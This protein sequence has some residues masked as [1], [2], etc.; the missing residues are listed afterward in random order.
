MPVT[1]L[2]ET[3]LQALGAHSVGEPAPQLPPLHVSLFVHALPSEHAA[4]SLPATLPQPLTASQVSTVHGFASVQSLF[5]G[6]PAHL[7][8]AHLSLWVQ[9]TS[10]LQLA[11]LNVGTQ[12]VADRVNMGVK[13]WRDAGL[14]VDVKPLAY[15]PEVDAVSPETLMRER[16][17]MQRQRQ[18][19]GRRLLSLRGAGSVVVGAFDEMRG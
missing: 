11:V 14:N 12:P 9:E 16:L 2:H 13:R 7:P 17:Q 3:V 18:Q 6:V 8:L 5:V 19:G 1:T 4:P 15:R 10:S